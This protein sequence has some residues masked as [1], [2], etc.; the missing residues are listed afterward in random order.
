MLFNNTGS[1]CTGKSLEKLCTYQCQA[2]LPPPGNTWG[3]VCLARITLPSGE[4]FVN[5]ICI[6][7]TI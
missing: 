7:I 5:V 2:L 6:C 3:F 4:D 1:S